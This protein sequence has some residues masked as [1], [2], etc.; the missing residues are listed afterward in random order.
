MVAMAEPWRHPDTGTYYLRRQIPKPLRDEFGGRQLWKKSLET[1]DPGEARRVF[2]AAN[3]ELEARFAAARTAI[4][5]RSAGK[6]LTATQAEAALTRASALHRGS[7]LDRFPALSNVYWAEEAAASKL[8]GARVSLFND[9]SPAGFAAMDPSHLPGDVWLRVVRTRPRNEVL[10]MAEHMIAWIHGDFR[11]EGS[12]FGDIVRSSDNDWSLT[13]AVT[14]AIER[15]QADLRSLIASPFRPTETRLRP[16]ML[17]GELLTEWRNKTP[18][19]GQQGAHETGTTVEDFIDFAGDMPVAQISGDHLYNFRDAV[20]SLPKAM[21]LAYRAL[22]FNARMAA[23]RELRGPKVA[24]ASVKRRVGHLQALLTH[25]FYNRWIEANSGTGIRIEG[26]SKNTGGRRPFLDD[27]LTQLFASDLFLRPKEWSER[28]DS[29]GDLTLAWL[30]LLGLTN[31]AR[32]EEIGQ[33][34]IANVKRDGGVLYLD[35]GIDAVVKNETSRR[36]IPIHNLV[37]ALGFENYVEALKS[38]GQTRLFPDLR[39]NKFDK[40]C[41]AA[42]RVGNRL[43]DKV[44]SKDPRIA[45]H[46][47]RHNFKDLARDVPIEKYIV[48]QIMGHAGITA[49]DKYG[50]GASLKTLKRELDRVTFEMVDWTAV[51]AAFATVDWNKSV[52]RRS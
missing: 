17:L 18:A 47:L 30:F 43:I 20:A 36:M 28:R 27:E 1:K 33:T 51:R 5:E 21:P 7:R 45:F 26:Y 19:P 23:C 52:S 3:A 48:E 10:F 22:T 14:A 4:A 38:D 9:P 41:Q 31:G 42:S 8:G 39:P 11:S 25:A 12:G 44:V 46:S 29:V 49:G 13:E 37:L 34:E 32:I 35:L 24:P 16:N 15:E 40:L 50:I 6:K 2:T